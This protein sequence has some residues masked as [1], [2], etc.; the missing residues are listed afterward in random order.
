MRKELRGRLGLFGLALA[1]VILTGGGVANAASAPAETPAA[2]AAPLR[3][4]ATPPRPDFSRVYPYEEIVGFL[5]AYHAAYPQHTR[6]ESIG[7]SREGRDLWMITVWNPATGPEMGKPAMYIDGNTHANEVQ[8]TETALYTVDFLLKSYGKLPRVTELLD[9]AVFYILPVVNPDGRT[10]WFQGPSDSGFPRTVLVP[11]DDD[12]DGRTDEDGFDDLDGDGVLTQMRKKVPPGQGTHRLDP[13]DPRLLVPA[14]PEELGDYLLLGDEGRDDDGDG[15]V[16]EDPVGYVDPNRTFGYFWEPSYVQ[17][18][19]GSYPLS[20]PETRAIATWALAHPNVAAVQSYHNSGGMILRGPGAKSDPAYSAQDLKVYDLIGR[21]GEKMLPGYRYL[22]SWKDLYT[23]HG[24]TTDHFYGIHGVVSF[25][26]ELY[27]GQLED[28][29]RN[30]TVSDEERLRFNDVLALGRQFVDWKPANH[31]QYGPV[32]IG[33]YRQDVGRVPEGWILQEEAHRNNAFVLFHAHHMPRLSLG[34]VRAVKLGDRL[35]RL[36][37][38]V[39]NDRATPTMTTHA[40][41]ERLHRPDVATVRGGKVLSSGLIEDLY[42]DR[43]TLQK[44]RPERLLV[45]GVDG[46]S[47]RMLF[48]L[49]EGDGE[50]TVEY[51][52]LKGG[53]LTK[54]VALREG[55]K[56]A[57]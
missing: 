30:G 15:K 19:S 25:T 5:K 2:I 50:V 4:A 48:F 54:K 32:E 44:H 6:L 8:G 26:N 42:L 56:A 9:R 3:A 37:V 33:G 18:G 53:K 21:E 43:V 1:G 29:D 35:W 10:L 31:P 22:I 14:G 34:D 38:P 51:D 55:G 13:R 24:A 7:K 11:V 49:V 57:R 28:L 52:S 40:R 20:I 23:T 46:L 41:Q 27:A 47:T 16:N 17:V 12:R 39:V 36:E 45:P